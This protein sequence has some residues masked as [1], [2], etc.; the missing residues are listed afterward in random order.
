[1]SRLT[2]ALPKEKRLSA[3]AAALRAAGL[4]APDPEAADVSRRLVH[5]DG[6]GT[7]YL[8]L[9][10]AD[11]PTFV[12]HGVAELGIAGK[13]ALLESGRRV[14]ELLDLGFAAC[15][16]VFAAP[17][18]AVR[19]AREAAATASGDLLE[20]LA[21]GRAHLRV[22]TKFPRMAEQRLAALRRPAEVIPL[23]GNVELAPAVGLADAIFDLVETGRTLRE[24]GLVEVEEVAR[25]TARLIANGAALRL[26]RAELERIAAALRRSSGWGDRHGDPR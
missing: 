19:R 25:S 5:V 10:A 2:I 17:A 16:F 1:M 4:D 24:N 15:R 6:A 21:A 23:H 12:E 13:D 3:C 26:R 11:V 7:R 9:R 22:A 18:E 8:I 20:H 14:Y